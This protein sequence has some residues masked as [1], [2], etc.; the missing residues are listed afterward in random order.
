MKG[1]I[2]YRFN[3]IRSLI[4][5]D[6]VEELSMHKIDQLVRVLE[7]V[8]VLVGGQYAFEVDRC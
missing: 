4:N 2:R 7:L 8:D 1:P 3:E 5:P 6:P